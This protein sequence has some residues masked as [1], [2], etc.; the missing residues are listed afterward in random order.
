MMLDFSGIVPSAEKVHNFGKARSKTRKQWSQEMSAENGIYVGAE[1]RPK[2]AS[3]YD[4]GSIAV[5]LKDGI[6][7]VSRCFLF[8]LK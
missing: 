8:L 2:T 1:V 3:L 7:K 6:P 4:A 5:L